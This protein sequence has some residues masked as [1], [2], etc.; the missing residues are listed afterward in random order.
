[1]A[2]GSLSHEMEW[3]AKRAALL[4]P[5]FED[6]FER[7]YWSRYIRM[8]EKRIVYY[9][10][11]TRRRGRWA[12]WLQRYVESELERRNAW[13]CG[14]EKRSLYL[15][16]GDAAELYVNS[17]GFFATENVGLFPESVSGIDQPRVW[18]SLHPVLL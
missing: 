7:E 12:P 14:Y 6:S 11:A 3:S 17:S 8:E 5:V 18:L 13:I 9:I 1:M 15:P 10:N 2:K 16:E 4:G